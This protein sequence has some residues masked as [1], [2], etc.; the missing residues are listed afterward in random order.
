MQPTQTGI[1]VALALVVVIMFFMLP[2]LSPFG[3]TPVD[4]SQTLPID[5]EQSASNIMPTENVTQL[6]MVDIV[7]GTG[8]VATAGDSVTVNYVG[9]L[10][11]GTVFDA[12]ANRGNEGLT[13]T[14]GV[15]QVIK[16]WDLGVAGMKEGGKR[17]LV[18][19]A[20]LAYGDQAVGGVIPANSTLVFEVELL[21]VQKAK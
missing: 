5:T 8:A 9:S 3:R 20:S 12:S 16:G 17:K 1:A 21:K 19:P 15:G 4:Q 6:Q 18:I 2:G 10:T 7:I 11:N 13:F 14:L